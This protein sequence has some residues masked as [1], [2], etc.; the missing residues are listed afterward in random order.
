MQQM[1]QVAT[2]PSPIKAV[3]TQDDV[4][5]ASVVLIQHLI[6]SYSTDVN[7]SRPADVSRDPDD[8]SDAPASVAVANDDDTKPDNLMRR[9]RTCTVPVRATPVPAVSQLMEMGFARRK[10]EAAVKQL[11]LTLSLVMCLCF[12]QSV[13]G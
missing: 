13:S 10:A 7:V 12:Q 4:E 11:G 5:L 3:F 9:R 1:M 2:Q 6:A 8:H